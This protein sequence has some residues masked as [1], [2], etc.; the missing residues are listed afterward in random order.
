VTDAAPTFKLTHYP[1]L[2]ETDDSVPSG[3]SLGVR[4]VTH[5]NSGSDS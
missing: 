2:Y 3:G 1:L 4:P 5:T